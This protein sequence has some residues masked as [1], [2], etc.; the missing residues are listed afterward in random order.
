MQDLT[1]DSR[2]SA[3]DKMMQNRKELNDILQN[4]FLTKTTDQWITIL[5]ANNILCAQINTPSEAFQDPQILENEMVLTI[6]HHGD[7]EIKVMGIPIKLSNTPGSVNSAPPTLGQH[8]DEILKE[9][10]Y[11]TSQIV[12]LRQQKIVS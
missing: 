1:R 11:N 6:N 10:G 12:T 3:I 8:T 4:I 2:F 5:E 9:V 7:D